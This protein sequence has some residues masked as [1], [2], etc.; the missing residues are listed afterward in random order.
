MNNLPFTNSKVTVQFSKNIKV[1][2]GFYF[3]NEGA[4]RYSIPVG[5]KHK[6]LDFYSFCVIL[7]NRFESQYPEI[8]RQMMNHNNSI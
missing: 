6:G 3:D 2:L 4:I 1:E 8:E 5:T 7:H